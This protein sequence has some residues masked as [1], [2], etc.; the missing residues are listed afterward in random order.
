MFFF[1]AVNSGTLKAKKT[2]VLKPRASDIYR[3]VYIKDVIVNGCLTKPATCKCCLHLLDDLSSVPC[4][5]VIFSQ[6]LVA[7]SVSV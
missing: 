2:F 7:G 5:L 4:Y 6:C 1:S 3:S